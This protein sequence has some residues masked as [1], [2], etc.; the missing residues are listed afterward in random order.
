MGQPDRAIADYT[1]ILKLNPAATASA[2]IAASILRKG[3]GGAL[4]TSTRR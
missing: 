4:P 3:I 2:T 1:G